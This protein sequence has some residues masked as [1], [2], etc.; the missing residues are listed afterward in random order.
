MRKRYTVLALA[1]VLAITLAVPAL[2]GPSNPIAQVAGSGG[3]A[4]KKAKK[5]I[6]LAQAAQSSAD[7]AQNS[8]NNALNAANG[9]QTSADAANAAAA[10]AQASADAA[11]ANANTRIQ[12]VVARSQNVAASI[13]GSKSATAACN[14]GEVVVGGGFSVGGTSANRITPEASQPGI[15]GGWFAS[16]EVINGQTNP[17]WSFSTFAMCGQK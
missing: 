2:G 7:N 17:S 8:A 5:G 16:A 14:A 6:R 12:N 3:K 11:N 1:A 10:A 15:Y 9:A 13:N 4:L